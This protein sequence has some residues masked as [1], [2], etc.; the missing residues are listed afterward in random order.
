MPKV[1]AGKKLI[2]LAVTLGALLAPQAASAAIPSVFNGDVSC[3]VEGDGVRY[4]G[5]TGPRTTTPSFDGAPIDVSAAFPAEPP[6]GPDG[7]YP[8]VML[9]HGYGGGKF[10]L[11]DM[12]HWVDQGYATFSMSDRGFHESCGS[13]ASVTAA[14]GDCDGVYIRLIDNRFEV[15]DAQY[16]AGELVDEGLVDPNAIGAQGG[17][18][19]GG[20]SMALG[21]LNDRVVNP[22]YSL[23]PWTSPEGT[24]LHMAATAPVIP[25]T[26]LAYSLAPNGS[27]LDY[28][29]DAPYTGPVGV[30]KKSFVTGL[31]ISGLVNGRY[32]AAG[33]DPT[34][35]VTGWKNLLDAGEPY[36][37]SAQAV[38][39]EMTQ[40]HSSYYIDHSEPPAPML[41]ASGF[42]DDLFPADETIRY[43]NR[44]KTQYPGADLKL[45]FG[46]FGHMRGANKSNDAAI[47]N[48]R[49]DSWFRYYL[50]GKGSRPAQGAEALT[51][52]CPHSAPSDGPYSAKSWA[53]MAPGEVRLSDG[54]TKVIAPDS[55]SGGHFNPVSEGDPCTTAPDDVPAGA[56]AYSFDP[57]PA[58]GY[59][60][61]GAATVVAK[62]QLASPTSQVAARLL[63]VAPDGTE[64]L[65][66]RG[67]WRPDPSGDAVKQVFQLHPNGW[68]FEEGHT[69]RLELLANDAVVPDPG[70]LG[71]Y[72]Q[73]SVGQGNVTVSDLEARLPVLEKPGSLGG[74]V[75][76]PA[77]KFLP[78][79]YDLAADFADLKAPGAQLVDSKLQVKGSKVTDE[80]SC[81]RAFDACHDGSL[82]LKA[83][84]KY[85]GKGVSFK[86]GSATFDEIDG[87]ATEKLTIKL[88]SNAKKFLAKKKPKLK[89][90]ATLK[91]GEVS[92]ARNSN[93]IL[94][95]KKN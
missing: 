52:T 29:A 86:I 84:D 46:D 68:T 24:P 50:K 23:S 16:F 10:G 76:A 43:Y 22:D 91:L 14:G 34:A 66:D 71:S 56:A 12:Q 44:T 81:P 11:S 45:F 4:C 36:G 55:S 35:D 38:I 57:A 28:V 31:Y 59:T 42:T 77:P 17:S 3:T 51:Q 8:L 75:K 80:V 85:K 20:M 26:D 47:L 41:M 74:L 88:S 92:T 65:V 73:A 5:G 83:N 49:I 33:T 69:P 70:G 7:T 62:F 54:S 2:V 27:T 67:L 37:D 15:R 79:G 63:D 6:S 1:P 32:A 18:Y 95:Q 72:G 58:G 48:N 25:W 30:Q 94:Y 82:S 89:Y 39:D 78:D 53:E 61:M 9:F 21:A 19:G 13:P 60:M 40:H 64:T 93:G 90:Q 87:G